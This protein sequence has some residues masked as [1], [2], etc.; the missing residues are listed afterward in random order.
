MK[1]IKFKV[2]SFIDIITNSST[3]IYVSAT[4][5]TVNAVYNLLE[6]ILISHNSPYRVHEVFNVYLI[7][8][9]CCSDEIMHIGIDINI[10]DP[11]HNRVVESIC[12]I[13]GSMRGV[14][15]Y[16]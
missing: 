10:E 13:M 14:E 9:E 8:D 4:D 2:H 16:N 15:I 3:E 1:T 6:T 12:K 11:L 5:N 7:E